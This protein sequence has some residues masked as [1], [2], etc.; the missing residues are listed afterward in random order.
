M[1]ELRSTKAKFTHF[2]GVEAKVEQKLLSGP[3]LPEVAGKNSEFLCRST[4][5]RTK[6][7]NNL[8][9]KSLRTQSNELS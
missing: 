8:Q 9:P 2:R 6:S 1:A 5:T 7:C 4:S 3:L